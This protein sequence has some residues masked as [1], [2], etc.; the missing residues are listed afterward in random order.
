MNVT[1]QCTR[2]LFMLLHTSLLW[3]RNI[4]PQQFFKMHYFFSLFAG[5]GRRRRT[6]STAA[7]AATGSRGL[8]TYTSWPGAVHHAESTSAG[9][10]A[11][12]DGCG[13]SGSCRRNAVLTRTCDSLIRDPVNIIRS[14]AASEPRTN[15]TNAIRNK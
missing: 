15:S 7:A 14:Q 6:T 5:D 8:A 1:L 11:A 10:P 2:Q 9:L 3:L 13:G 12:H 4:F